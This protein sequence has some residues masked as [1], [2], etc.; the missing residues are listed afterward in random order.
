MKLR[1]KILAHTITLVFLLGLSIA[2]F[3]NTSLK[4][5][6]LSDLREKG[7]SSTMHIAHMSMDDILTDN[8][9]S[10]QL[11]L[12]SQQTANKE[13]EYIYI[14]DAW[15]KILAH[16][17][18]EIFPKGLAKANIINKS[19]T[20]SIKTINTVK[21]DIIDIAIPISNG[22]LGFIHAGFS[23]KHIEEL[24][25]NTIE[26]ILLIIAIV[27][28]AVCVLAFI[29]S[30]VIT[31]PIRK[32]TYAA[33][34]IG[35]GKLDTD[36]NIESNDEIGEL[37]ASFNNMIRNLTNSMTSIQILNR[38]IAE[39]KKAEDA[40]Q[41]SEERYRNVVEDQ[42]DIICKFLPDGTYT[43]V[44]NVYC[45]F[46]KKSKGELIGSKWF[47]D[48]HPEDLEMIQNKLSTMSKENPVV[49]I[50][51]RIF[52]GYGTTHWIQFVN[53]GSY[54]QDGNL[55][56]IQSVGRD[57]TE[58][59]E[60]E[61]ELQKSQQLESIGVL[62]GGIAHDFNNL[63]S[64]INSNI[65]LSKNYVE[66]DSKGY[67]HL[68]SAEKAIHRATSLTEQ[69][70]TFSE[71]G[72]PVKKAA[73]ITEIIKESAEF[74]LSG[75][76]VTCNYNIA[77]DL[78]PVHV[79]KGQ[80]SQAIHN[81]ILNSNQAMPEGGTILVHVENS[82]HGLDAE[83]LTCEG[84]YVK[85]VIQD[86]GGGI[87]KDHL[88]M[89]FNPYFTTKDMGMGLGLSITY[90][91]INNHEGHISVSSEK[92]TGTSFTIYLPASETKTE[93]KE[94]VV[95][96]ALAGHGKILLMDDEELVREALGGILEINGYEIEHAENGEKAL[97]LYQKAIETSKPFDAVIL[98][99]TVRGGMGGKEAMK[100]LLEIDPDV[101]GIVSS[102]YSND[103]VVA[104]FKEY[105]FSDV[106]AKPCRSQDELNNVLHRVIN[107]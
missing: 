67:E 20:H 101:K 7:I 41:K 83:S 13:I 6:L 48:V 58:L 8:K 5:E 64:A 93:E 39:R 65:Y 98:D 42:T 33:K 55:L 107:A 69:L 25:D 9:L 87:E 38:E 43:F 22:Q 82:D 102:G 35:D 10:L 46:F 57:I 88:E 104:N 66:K 2:F 3:V 100:K 16:T 14:E 49:M 77:D 34:E 44:N 79:D 72:S 18:G 37:A 12:N 91:I 19:N 27:L 32:L 75:S 106:L 51:N 74:A 105:G 54:D 24:V 70:L 90:S 86:K 59:R 56:E 95:D 21:G 68:N 60:L 28:A 78:W 15:H 45:H 89:I 97:E 29:F 81:L 76:N 61:R 71:G 4:K 31:S 63:L 30:S 36:I 99:L 84:K 26:L 17:F 40:L 92:G 50:E 53:R 1:N 11:M 96:T 85:I 52:S 47:P 73:S 80:I 103:P 94:I 62:A 23:E